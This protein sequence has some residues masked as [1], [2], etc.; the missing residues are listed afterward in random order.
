[1]V[2]DYF[3]WRLWLGATTALGT[4]ENSELKIPRC[5]RGIFAAIYLVHFADTIWRNHGLHRRN[6]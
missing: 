2:H 5:V 3:G 4:K 1:M 6:S